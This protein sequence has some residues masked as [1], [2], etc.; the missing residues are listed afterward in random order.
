MP[1]VADA[2]AALAGLGLGATIALVIT[3][4]TRGSLD[5]PGGWLIAGGRLTGFT[6]AYLMLI[7][8]VL[9]ARLPWL[10][11]AVGQD[12]LVRWHRRIGPWPLVLIGAHVVLI[13]LGYAQLA[14]VGA[15]HQ[16]WVFLTSYPDVLAAAVGL[17]LLV[18]A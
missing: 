18:M 1:L 7:M 8:V 6:G 17:C 15:L 9:I 10:E 14:K 2:F 4:E 12:R 3:G 16:F 5:A 13:T 11:R